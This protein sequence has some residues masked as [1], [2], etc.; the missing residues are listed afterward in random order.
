LCQSI[1]SAEEL[2]HICTYSPSTQLGLSIQAYGIGSRLRPESRRRQI[3]ACDCVCIPNTGLGLELLTIVFA[4]EKFCLYVLGSRIIILSDHVALKFL[5]KKLDA[6]PRLIWWMLLL[7][8][9]NIEIEDKKGVENSVA[10][11]L[12]QIERE[13]DLIPI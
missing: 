3:S 4:L 5:L 1:P 8:E 6:K 11:H 9:F 7:Q 13:S 12:S 2:T 10:E